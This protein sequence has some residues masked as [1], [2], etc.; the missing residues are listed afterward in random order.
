MDTNLINDMLEGNDTLNSINELLD[1][2]LSIPDEALTPEAMKEFE[3]MFDNFFSYD[4][5]Q[6]MVQTLSNSYRR[7]HLSHDEVEAIMSDA[8]EGLQILIN[9]NNPTPEKRQ[10]LEIIFNHIH[11][12]FEQV[13]STYTTADIKLRIQLDEGAILPKYANPSDAATDLYINQ[14]VII[15]PHSLSNKVHTGVHI[16]LPEGWMAYIFP[17][18]STGAKTGL[19]LSNSVGIID[20]HYIGELILL[21]DNH[22]DSAI[23]LKTG[24]R[25]AQ[26]MIVPSYHFEAQVVDHLDETDRSDNGFGSTGK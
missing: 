24:E 5:Q 17:R 12:I 3:L 8:Q 18:S 6:R 4:L 2:V 23:A 20:N 7:E 15:P 19:R 16:G 9:T 1:N 22:S 21:F 26:L 11:T 10:L 13:S 14:D 25:L